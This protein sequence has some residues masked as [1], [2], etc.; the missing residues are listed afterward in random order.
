MKLYMGRGVLFSFFTCRH[1]A[2][3]SCQKKAYFRWPTRW[4]GAQANPVPQNKPLLGAHSAHLL[5]MSSWAFH[6]LCVDTWPEMMGEYGR[7][8][9]S[10]NVC[11]GT[12]EIPLHTFNGGLLISVRATQ[13]SIFQPHFTRRNVIQ[14]SGR[15]SKGSHLFSE[16]SPQ[17]GSLA[18]TSNSDQA[19][20]SV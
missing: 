11:P 5:P 7:Y 6:L 13:T 12:H 19:P 15:I 20:T 14:G 4:P 9:F 16:I 2:H 3:A 17:H 10:P 18:F 8:T 1:T